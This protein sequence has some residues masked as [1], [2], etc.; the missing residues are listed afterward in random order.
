MSIALATIAIAVVVGLRLASS[1]SPGASR[2]PSPNPPS[3]PASAPSSETPTYA[4]AM[5]QSDMPS[6]TPSATPAMS[7]A[8]G[9]IEPCQTNSLVIKG[10]R[11]GETGVVHAGV[12][13]TN[14]GPNACSLPGLP[15]RVDLVRTDGKSLDLKVEPPLGDPSV[16]VVLRPKVTSDAEL[17]FYWMNWCHASPGP[18]QVRITLAGIQGVVEGP[19][20]GPLLPRCDAP[21][22]P[23][24][25][26]ID[27]I[28]GN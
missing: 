24:A 8:P 25:I 15:A 9:R 7:D 18:L 3:P 28:S 6:L 16:T 1:T 2:L 14:I 10:G 20:E 13:I 22:E 21:S 17:V 12:A 11:D 23:S 5:L 19:L 27:G 4:T 26:Q